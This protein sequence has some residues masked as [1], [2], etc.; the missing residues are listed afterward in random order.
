MKRVY[1]F[2]AGKT[3][4]NLPENDQKNRKRLMVI[5]EIAIFKHHKQAQSDVFL[6]NSF[7]LN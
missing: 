4:K 7:R 1:W 5:K 3:R 2:I 6:I